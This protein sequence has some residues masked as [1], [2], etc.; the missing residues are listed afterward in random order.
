VTTDHHRLLKR[1]AFNESRHFSRDILFPANTMAYDNIGAY[2]GIG[3]CLPT[4]TAGVLFYLA[5]SWGLWWCFTTIL[6]H[7]PRLIDSTTHFLSLGNKKVQ[8]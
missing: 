5:L 2:S 1:L 3:P 4:Q 6:S 7:F 8:E